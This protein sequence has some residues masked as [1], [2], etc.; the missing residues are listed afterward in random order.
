MELDQAKRID[1]YQKAQK[2]IVDDAPI[3]FINVLPYHTA[4][5]KKIGN[6]PLTIWGAMSPLDEVYIK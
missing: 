5:S 2:I 3:A 4:Y 6:P 1:L